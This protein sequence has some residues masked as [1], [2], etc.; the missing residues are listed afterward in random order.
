MPP[1]GRTGPGQVGIA[2]TNDN[3]RLLWVSDVRPGAPRRAQP[4]G[5]TSSLPTRA[6][7]LGAIADLDGSDPDAD[8]AVIIGYKTARNRPLIRSQKL[9]NKAL[10]AGRTPVEHG[11]VH[12]KYWRVLGKVRADP[13]WATA[14]MRALLVLTNREVA[15]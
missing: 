9:S 14:L 3:G 12:L 10:A 7:G 8:P 13:N 2:L 6:A 15:R 1:S 4:V 5:T 11:F